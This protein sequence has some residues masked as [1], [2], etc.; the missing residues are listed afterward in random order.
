MELPYP[1]IMQAIRQAAGE[2]PVYLV[3]GS[4]RDLVLNRPLHDLDF[5][6]S[7]QALKLARRVANALGGAFYALDSQRDTG[8]AILEQPDGSRL[9]LDFAAF[10]A[11]DLTGDQMDRDFTLNAMALD[12]AQPE[13]LIDPLQGL[14]DL[15]ARTLRACA[16]TCFNH[17][18][19]RI[20]RAVRMAT[21]LGLR[22]EPHTLG[23]LKQAM[24]LLADVSKE[25]VRDE[26]FKIL[27]GP[28]PASAIRTLQ[29]VGAAAVIL[30]DTTA[31]LSVKQSPPHIKDVW[32]HS[33]DAV[34]HLAELLDSLK[35]QSA[36]GENTTW[37][38]G[39]VSLRIGRYRSQLAEHMA[40]ALNPERSLRSLLLLAALYHDA[41]K[42]QTR[43][44]DPDGRIRYFDHERAGAQI[45]GV[46]ATRLHLSGAEVERLKMI[47]RVHMRPNLMAMN[48][49]SPPTRRAIYRY[50][51]D[52]GAAGVDAALLS[53]ADTL[54]TYGPGLPEKTWARQ[55]DVV[56]ALL[57]A[58]WEQ[59]QASI[60][61]PALIDGKDL[62]EIC[63]LKP[64]PE[65]GRLLE[66]IR[67]AQ[68]SG[69]IQDRQQ[70][71]DYLRQRCNPQG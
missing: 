59:P 66:E 61:P 65:V 46:Q 8:R 31:M 70:A 29:M 21:S 7:E 64:G 3:G 60:A 55:L 63:G 48:E 12:I 33:L 15:R 19:V 67:E 71:L 49:D 56:R 9:I 2:Q 22:I 27:D 62:M 43:T 51:R 39:L 40:Q 32:E 41:G 14:Q 26:L 10:R 37:R 24:P 6:L 45:A 25:R 35:G 54:A 5:V 50:F 36:P 4:V 58:W 69:D 1:E 47:I 38:M 16:P 11:A 17:D 42:P 13:K 18:P 34:A 53:L 28:A 68:I 52:A 30:P 23:W 44:L 57:E 20:L